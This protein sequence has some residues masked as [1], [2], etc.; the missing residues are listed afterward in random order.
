MAD[1]ILQLCVVIVVA[2]ALGSLAQRLGQGRV[3]GELLAG[4]L[5]GPSAFGGLTAVGH[6]ALI[7]QETAALLSR[8]GE[9]GLVFLMF[10]TGMHITWKIAQKRSAGLV[11]SVIAGLGMALP[12]A[13]GCAIAVASSGS[14]Q[15]QASP[16][17]YV[18]FCGIALSVSA[19]PVMMRIV[20]DARIT[21]RPSATLSIF[22]ATL[23]DSLGWL[24]LAAVGAI[25]TS[26]LSPA[27]TVRTMCMLVAFVVLSIALA[28]GIVLRLL[29]WTR[30]AGS[31]SATLICALCYVLLSSWG[32]SRLGFHG[33][34]GAL[35]AAANLA[36]RDD[37]R[38]LWDARFAG[39]AD[40]VL[41][42]LFFV[43]MGFQAS[44]S[45]LDTGAAWG[46][47]VAFLIGGVAAKFAGCYM[48]ARL[49]GIDHAE[50]TLI[51]VLM[52]CRGTVELMVLA[53][54]LQLRIIPASLY[55][56]LLIAT[57][58]MTWLSAMS[59]HRLAQRLPL[60]ESAAGC[61]T[62]HAPAADGAV[63][64][65]RLPEASRPSR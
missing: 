46:W 5:L 61:R 56:V 38:R 47:L 28:R 13:T 33:A 31:G 12:F 57:L 55:T 63:R 29:D 6:G 18:L 35:V 43:S 4:L 53:I 64:L 52:N 37:L 24:I 3:I 62:L 48:G 65:P 1:W 15:P 9:L 14:F 10:Q 17:A 27:S 20:A 11:A 49:C 25:A 23:T 34:F 40:L 39:L 60:R 21:Q 41:I 2:F 7:G 59:T 42:P 30:R 32:A 58:T 22:A 51:G 44:F 54:G 8:L 16:L 26:R 36:G 19:L 50:A 45:A